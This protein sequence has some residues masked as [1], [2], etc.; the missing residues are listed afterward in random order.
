MGKVCI[1]FVYSKKTLSK[2]Q[3]SEAPDP[4]PF[5]LFLFPQIVKS[6]YEIIQWMQFPK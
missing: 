6:D 5:P 3:R 4:V 1:G 2:A